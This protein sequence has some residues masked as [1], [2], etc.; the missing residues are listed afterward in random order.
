[1]LFDS[2]AHYDDS[3][4]NSDRD[5]LLP[6]IKENG[7]DLI[8][9]VGSDLQTSKSSIALAKMYDFVYAAIGV[10]PHDAKDMDEK[11]L[12]ELVILSKE[13]K[14]VAIGEIGLDYYY[15]NS[16]RETQKYWFRKQL[17]LAK[18]LHLPVIIHD[19]DA[20]GDCM[21][22]LKQEAPLKGVLHSFS[23]SVEMA[24]EA[25]RLG[26]VISI[27]GPLTYKNN[28]KTVEVVRQIPLDYLLIETDSPYLPPEPHRGE[29]NT[30]LNVKYVAQKIADIKGISFDEVCHRTS[31]NATSLFSIPSG[32]LSR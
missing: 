7:V 21:D 2:H 4:F 14:V 28:H 8:V 19:R 32:R 25:I 12:A 22:I 13:K 9:N 31:E 3:K 20:H 29:R 5:S 24:N 27:S 10:H 1:M 26:M 16:P 23:G 30:S 17:K 11:V 18:Q 6:S 15:D